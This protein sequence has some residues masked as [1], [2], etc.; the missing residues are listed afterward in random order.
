VIYRGAFTIGDIPWGVYS[1]S[2]YDDV[3]RKLFT[4]SKRQTD[5]HITT[6]I[7]ETMKIKILTFMSVVKIIVIKL[8]K[9]QRGQNKTASSCG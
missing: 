4:Q 1:C 7:Y 8:G 6:G 5:R 9:F 2:Q 3:K